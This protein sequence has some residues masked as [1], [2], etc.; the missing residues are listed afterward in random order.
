MENRRTPNGSYVALQEETN[1]Q[2]S[3]VEVVVPPGGGPP[4]HTHLNEDEGFYVLEGKFTVWVN[5]RPKKIGIGEHAFGPRNIQHYFRNTGE[6]PGTLLLVFSPG[7][8]EK[9]FLELAE[10]RAQNPPDLL[11]QVEAIDK[12][13]GTIINRRL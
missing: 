9:Y 6:I 10:V 13:Y 2:Y 4:P 7:G 8:Y 5:G 1:G 11:E 12:K 3:L